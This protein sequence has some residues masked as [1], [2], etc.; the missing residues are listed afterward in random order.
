MTG[1]E[2]LHEEHRGARVDRERKVQL[3]GA[4]GGEVTRRRHRVV[5]DQDV[6]SVKTFDRLF[7]HSAGST[8]GSW[9]CDEFACRRPFDV[10]RDRNLNKETQRCLW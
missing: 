2:R 9:V 7:D 10:V 5:S 1:R 6:D 4:H 8:V 3:F